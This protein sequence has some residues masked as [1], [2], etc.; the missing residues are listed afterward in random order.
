METIFSGLAGKIIGGLATF[1]IVQFILFL[2]FIRR[3]LREI[4]RS[5]ETMK[6]NIANIHSGT[7]RLNMMHDKPDAF[8]FG[9]AITEKY[10]SEMLEEIRKLNDHIIRLLT[11]IER[12]GRGG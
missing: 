6:I 2:F 10:M 12:N 7:Q 9:T 4:V 8:G 3:T 11:I 1:V 5:M